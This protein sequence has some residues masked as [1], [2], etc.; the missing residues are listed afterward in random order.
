MVMGKRVL[1]ITFSLTGGAGRVAQELSR[2]QQVLGWDTELLTL[3]ATNLREQPISL[4]LHTAAAG[5]DNILIRKKS[6]PSLFSLTRDSI[7]GMD[8][9]TM[10]GIEVI[11]LHWING[12]TGL[13]ELA[14]TFPKIPIIWTLHDMNPFTGGCHQS[15]G[16]YGY[17][18]GCRQCPAVRGIFDKAVER[19]LTQKARAVKD[20]RNLTVVAPNPWIDE[21]A[22]A[23]QI[24]GNTAR[25]IIANPVRSEFFEFAEHPTSNHHETPYFI[26]VASDTADP[27][28]RVDFALECFRLLVSEKGVDVRLKIVGKNAHSFRDQDHID[29]YEN[30]SLEEL[31][32]LLQKSAALL[33]PSLAETAPLV[34]SEAAALGTEAIVSDIPSL[35]RMLSWIG[36]G[37]KA[38]S[39]EEWVRAMLRALRDTSSPQSHSRK[40]QLISRGAELFHP[41]NVA[42]SYVNLYERV[43]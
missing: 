41:L 37:E 3:T 35:S 16:C 8:L 23:S 19:N 38:T 21:A 24:F 31:R 25:E 34:I 18:S 2:S 5:V 42:Q 36:A 15:L 6:F 28:K 17:T 11:N 12:V 43:L 27:L 22:G 20:T 33:V 30:P 26:I 7:R 1:H 40:Q 14:T 10:D 9:G 39:T 29:V 32:S 13:R 4:P